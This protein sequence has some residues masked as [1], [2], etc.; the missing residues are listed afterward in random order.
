MSQRPRDILE[1]LRRAGGG[2]PPVAEEVA[3]EAETTSRIFV[4]PPVSA[5][6]VVAAR[7]AGEPIELTPRQ[8]LIA[9]LAALLLAI[10]TYMVGHMVGGNSADQAISSA[11]VSLW[12]IRVVSYDDTRSGEISAKTWASK[13]ERLADDEVTIERLD[14][15]RKLVVT[16]GSW[17]KNPR[18]NERALRLLQWVQNLESKGGTKKPFDDACFYSIKR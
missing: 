4:S 10:L 7:G 6:P 13:I 12:T 15:D 14:R 18:E 11:P 17:L 9:G 2:G 1:F 5:Q 3:E 16:L 8:A